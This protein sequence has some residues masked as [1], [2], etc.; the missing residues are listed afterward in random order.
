MAIYGLL[1]F[2]NCKDFLD[3]DELNYETKNYVICS[4]LNLFPIIFLAKV[5]II[6]HLYLT[7]FL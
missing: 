5:G 7:V 3:P 2:K 4:L 6:N 1:S